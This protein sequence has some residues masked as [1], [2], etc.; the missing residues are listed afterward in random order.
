ML[1]GDLDRQTSVELKGETR[2]NNLVWMLSPVANVKLEQKRG[3]N[4]EP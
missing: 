2:G 4:T 1:N 3:P